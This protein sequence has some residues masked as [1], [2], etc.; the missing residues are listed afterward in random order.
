MQQVRTGL[1]RLMMNFAT[2]EKYA[3]VQPVIYIPVGKEA[4]TVSNVC[5]WL[6]VPLMYVRKKYED[7]LLLT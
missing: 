3:K 2:K 4:D 5:W 7:M 6:C 1:T